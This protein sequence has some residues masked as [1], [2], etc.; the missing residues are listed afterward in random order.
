[1]PTPAVKPLPPPNKKSPNTTMDQLHE[2]LSNLA[3]QTRVIENTAD[4]EKRP[5][6]DDEVKTIRQLN[7]DFEAVEAEIEVRNHSQRMEERLSAGQGRRTQ[8]ADVE[9]DEADE[10]EP[11]PAANTKAAARARAAAR[12]HHITGGEPAG[13]T[14]GSRGFRSI[15]EFAIA[16]KLTLTGKHDPRIMNAPT[17]FGQE[18][19]GS[20]GGFALPPDFRQEI[21]KQVMG[22]D[23][24]LSRTDQQTTSSNALTLPLDTTTPWQTSGGVLGSWMGEG[25]T[26]GITKPKLGQLECKANKLGALV[27]ITDELLEDVP[28]MT[29]WLQ[30]K[31]P[32]KFTS[33]I[34]D[35]IVNGDGNMKP[36]GMLNANCKITVAAESGQGAGTIVAKNIMKMW[37]RLYGRLRADAVWL[38]NQDSEQQ[39][40]QLVM[41]GTNPSFPAYMPPGGF[42][43]APYATLFGRPIIPLEAC[44]TVG[45]E[46]DIILTDPTQYL[47]VLKAG[48]MR[49]DVSIHLYFDSDHTAFRFVM[50][51]GGQSYWPAAVA[52]ANG[53]NTLSPIVTLNSTRT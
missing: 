28:A 26:I 14:K 8:P 30:S 25:G 37:G 16:A 49:T 47:T 33:L 15:G 21:M 12:G 23:S 1:M 45:T 4:A 40:Q 48:G 2:Q 29:R 11:L 10:E 13:A 32:E 5:M 42:S 53:S 31:V 51:I 22:E 41:P 52:R 6:T 19:V 17:T 35:A 7:A 24:L 36:L 20:D 46:G 39:L 44:Q 34:N 38:I 9:V 43:A 3:E 50:R 18:A 27:P